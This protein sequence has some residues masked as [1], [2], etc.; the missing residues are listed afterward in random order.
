VIPVLVLL[1]FG[2]V[3]ITAAIFWPSKAEPEA[4]ASV[5]PWRFPTLSGVRAQMPEPPA[6]IAA[7]ATVATAGT[8]PPAP[9]APILWPLLIDE[10]ATELERLERLR[11]VESFT[12]VPGPWAAGILTQAYAEERD[13]L[14]EAAV[15]AIAECGTLAE[16]VLAQALV[17]PTASERA[18][19]VDGFAKIGVL[20]PVIPLLDDPSLPVATSA[21]YALVRAQRADVIDAHFAAQADAARLEE[22]R[23]VLSAIA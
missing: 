3:L 11:I 16:P 23:A 1:V 22:I 15:V 18:L 12:F 10:T 13:E 19:A 17:S 4:A 6:P 14:R 2:I 20:E 5:K 7:V 8:E 9:P 21:A